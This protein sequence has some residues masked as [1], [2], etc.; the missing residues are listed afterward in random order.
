MKIV[1]LCLALMLFISGCM[2]YH[3]G[4]AKK[5]TTAPVPTIKKADTPLCDTKQVID[6][7]I[8]ARGG[9]GLLKKLG[10]VIYVGRGKSAPQNQEANFL[11]RTI[12]A[13]P[14]RIRDESEYEGGVK[15]V[16]VV[17]KDK[18]WIWANNEVKEMDAV[19]LR[20]VREQLYVNKLLTLLP[21]KEPGITLEALPDQ[22]KE[23]VIV[24]AMVVKAKDQRDV[25]LYFE[26][27]NGL[28]LCYKTRAFDPNTY[29]EKDHETYFTQYVSMQGIQ[30]PRR[31]VVYSDGNKSM[32]LYYDELKFLPQVDDVLFAKP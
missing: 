24:Q 7:A 2:P 23:G 13:L 25:T 10:A 29:I 22:R 31:W 3:E 15:F 32:E 27:E 21:L 26:K 20:W 11:F 16:Q 17:N 30:F 1:N 14:D 12:S 19:N 4:T 18:G 28:L 5:V 9:E 8:Q 6:R